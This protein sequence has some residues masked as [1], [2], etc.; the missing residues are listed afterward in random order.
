[1]FE[2]LTVPANAWFTVSFYIVAGLALIEVATTFI[3]MSISSIIDGFLPELD[4]DIDIP[5]VDIDGPDID[6]DIPEGDIDIE[7]ESPSLFMKALAWIKVDNVPFLILFILFLTAFSFVG[8]SIQILCHHLF[9]FYLHKVIAVPIAFVIGS[10]ISRRLA[11]WLGKYVLKDDTS[12]VS[13][14]SFIG[15]TAVIT[16]GT[17][18]HILAAEAKLYDEHGSA[19]R[20]QVKPDDD[21]E[22]LEEG[23]EIII[24]KKEGSY[25]RAII[26]SL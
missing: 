14:N 22:S 19:H 13:T 26:N 4:I 24:V 23:S 16:L 17:A 6:V 12:A 20:I 5:D 18:T 8:F 7:I 25:Y 10:P 1:M 21:I 9:G 15:S 11:F 3:G 2:L